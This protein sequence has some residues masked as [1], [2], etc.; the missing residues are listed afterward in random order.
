MRTPQEIFNGQSKIFCLDGATDM[1]EDF[2][3][4][5]ILAGHNKEDTVKAVGEHYRQCEEVAETK[6][7]RGLKIAGKHIDNWL[8]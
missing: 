2:A 6:Y 7:I 4:R 1:L 3:A 8:N 5:C